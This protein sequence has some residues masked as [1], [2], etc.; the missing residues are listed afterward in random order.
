MTHQRSGAYHGGMKVLSDPSRVSALDTWLR[1]A[2]VA[3]TSAPSVGVDSPHVAAAPFSGE[4]RDTA[5][6]LLNLDA[7]AD[8]PQ[9]A[10]RLISASPPPGSLTG[11][12]PTAWAEHILAPL[13]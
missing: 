3:K 6:I 5:E 7:W 1:D 8:A 4:P 2:E 12:G 11:P 13:L 9:A 10:R